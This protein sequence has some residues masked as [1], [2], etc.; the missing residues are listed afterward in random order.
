MEQP[1]KHGQLSLSNWKPEHAKRRLSLMTRHANEVAAY[2][3]GTDPNNQTKDFG[4]HGTG[5]SGQGS[6]S[7]GGAAGADYQTSSADS[8]G[9]C[10]STGGATGY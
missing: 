2:H 3:R 9:D 10:D 5:F 7:S 6:L 1:P 4:A 8:I